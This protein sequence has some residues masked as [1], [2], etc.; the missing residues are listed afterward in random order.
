MLITMRPVCSENIYEC[1]RLSITEE[2]HNESQI[3][4]M[5]ELLEKLSGLQDVEQQTFYAGETMVGYAAYEH[6]VGTTEYA[7][8]YFLIDER[9]QRSGYGTGAFQQLLD[10]L[11]ANADCTM[12]K[13]RYMDFNEAARALYVKFGFVETAESDGYVDAILLCQ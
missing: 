3:P 6:E 8:L 9:W 2:Q 13:I 7:V 10:K 11:K 4:E 1:A 12:I 5:V